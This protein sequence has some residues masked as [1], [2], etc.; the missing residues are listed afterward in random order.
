MAAALAL[1][2]VATAWGQG[3]PG[4]PDAKTANH[5]PMV[6]IVSPKADGTYQENAQVHY[7]I[8]VSDQEDGESKFQEINS[9]EVLLTVRHFSSLETAEAARSR[10]IADDAPGLG[11][12]RTS[13]CLN[14]HSFDARLIG[15]SFADIRKRYSYSQANV[16]SLSRHI[17]QGASGAWGRTKMPSHPDLTMEQAAACVTWILNTAAD[18]QTSYYAGTEGSFRITV[19]PDSNSKD[20][21]VLV[22]TASYTDHGLKDDPSQRMQGRDAMLIRIR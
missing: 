1:V 3:A 20:K 21:G 22:L 2:S 9:T 10:T 7:E 18:P 11:A 5:P 17:L 13:D 6:K 14:C 16:D 19:P 4:N 12:L 8:D 15:P